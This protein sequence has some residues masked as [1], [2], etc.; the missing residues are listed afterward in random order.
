LIRDVVAVPETFINIQMATG[1]KNISA[2]QGMDLL[3][4]G[5]QAR[6][7]ECCRNYFT[8]TREDFGDYQTVLAGT[9]LL[10][11]F[12]SFLKRYGHRGIYETDMAQPR[13]REQPDYLLFAIR[14]MV[15][16]EQFITAEQMRAQQEAE[17]TNEWQQLAERLRARSLLAPFKL[18]FIRWQLR[19]LKKLF[20][21][22]E[23]VRYEGVRVIAAVRTFH[24][25]LAAR[26]QREGHIASQQDYFM[27]EPQELIQAFTTD[28]LNTLQSIIEQ[29][30]ARYDFYQKL[31]M[32]NLLHESE[33]STITTRTQTTTAGVKF[34]GLAVSSGA[35]AG[36]V[37]VINSPAEFAKMK[38]GCILVAPAT[39]P[40]WT[41]LFTLAAGVIVEIGGMLSHG[42]IVAREYGL[43]TVVNIPGITKRLHD[44]D[45]VL[46]NG[47]NGTVEVLSAKQASEVISH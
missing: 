47:S 33:I 43:P 6:N 9:P 23:R 21:L 46:I 19:G 12:Q 14:N 37:V 39:D 40:A 36:E 30:K 13:Y 26:L 17:A 25:Q 3:E 2:Q 32:P 38:P 28:K 44:G 22:R 42:S 15:N 7:D 35:I 29:S 4:M 41:P 11:S 24:L 10:A 27:L 8:P 31:D 18:A 20:V 5:Y 34:K 1:E 16:T 45:R